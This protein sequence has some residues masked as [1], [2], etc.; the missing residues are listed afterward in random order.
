M[1]SGV[2]GIFV[3]CIVKPIAMISMQINETTPI[4]VDYMQDR[5]RLPMTEIEDGAYVHMV[6][7]GS[8]TAT[9]ATLHGQLDFIWS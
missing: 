1:Q 8:T 2:G 9:P 6:G 3:A 4:E 7:H 5:L